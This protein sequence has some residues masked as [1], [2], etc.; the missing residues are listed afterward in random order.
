MN[1]QVALMGL[2]G[3]G[4]SSLGKIIAKTLNIIHIDTDVLI[5]N[6]IGLSVF[7]I[8]I[9]HNEERFRFIEEEIVLAS[10]LSQKGIISLGGGSATLPEVCEILLNHTV[11]YLKV[12]A[13]KGIQRIKHKNKHPL[14]L[15]PYQAD[16]YRY[17]L[18]TREIV[19]RE[20]A[21]IEVNTE[22][23][24][25]KKTVSTIVKQLEMYMSKIFDTTV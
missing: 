16:K 1:L 21:S 18:Q 12:T 3:S 23:K 24:N 22:Q 17:L 20:L 6:T 15:P 9:T 19:Y 25:L 2:P 10:L 13:D 8:F 7:K 5:E 14:L 4:K 11:V